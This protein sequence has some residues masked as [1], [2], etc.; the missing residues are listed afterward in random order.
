MV[1]RFGTVL[2]FLANFVL[3]LWLLYLG[4]WAYKSTVA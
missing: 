1:L 3:G 4:P 2:G